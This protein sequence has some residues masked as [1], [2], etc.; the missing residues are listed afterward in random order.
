ML[1]LGTLNYI[2]FWIAYKYMVQNRMYDGYSHV[3]NRIDW[4]IT[5]THL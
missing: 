5:V 4:L 3:K 1:P 2:V